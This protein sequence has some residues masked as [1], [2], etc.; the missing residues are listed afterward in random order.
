MAQVKETSSSEQEEEEGEEGEEA[1]EGEEGG[2][3]DN[4]L[5][6]HIAGCELELVRHEVNNMDI[7]RSLSDALECGMA[8]KH[9]MTGKLDTTTIDIGAL[10][11][12]LQEVTHVVQ[13]FMWT[14]AIQAVRTH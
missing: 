14:S 9:P 3:D 2:T 8:M 11:T 1:E 7:I 12:A 10:Q 5:G 13:R 4:A 6:Q